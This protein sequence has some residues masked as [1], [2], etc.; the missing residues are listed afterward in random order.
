MRRASFMFASLAALAL[1]LTPAVA[2]ARAGGGGSSGSRGSRTQSA[3]APTNTAP[4]TAQPMQRTMTPASPTAAT[5]AAARPGAPAAAAPSRWGGSFAAGYVWMSSR[6]YL[7]YHW[8]E[9]SEDMEAW[10]EKMGPAATEMYE[11]V[12]FLE[13][14]VSG[15]TVMLPV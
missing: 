1:V 6:A 10:A 5:P 2:D 4:G 9:T 3:P 12:S 11:K 15:W 8:I 14:Y 13:G 7:Y